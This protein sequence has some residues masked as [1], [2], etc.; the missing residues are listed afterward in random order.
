MLVKYRTL[1][2]REKEKRKEEK[3][4]YESCKFGEDSRFWH[5]IT[6]SA[7]CAFISACFTWFQLV[8]FGFKLPTLV[9]CLSERAKV[10]FE[11]PNISKFI[12]EE[13]AKSDL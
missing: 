3:K 5:W 2:K 9:T 1:G 6:V 11:I 13:V 8:A 7:L 10:S 4:V 12:M